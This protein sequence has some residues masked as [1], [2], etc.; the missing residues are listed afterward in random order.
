[1]KILEVEIF[2]PNEEEC[3]R[4]VEFNENDLSIIYGNI[5]MPT[6]KKA[7]SNSIGKTVL[8]KIVNVI[9]G[10]NNSGKDTIKGLNDYRIKAKVK[11]KDRIHNVKLIIGNS[12]G[13]YVDDVKMPISK[14]KEYFEIDRGKFSKQIMLEKRKGMI[15][16]MAA[17]ATKEDYSTILKLLY[18]GEID[19]KFKEIKQRQDQIA[20][21][22]KY[23]N[24]FKVS[25]ESLEQKKF[26]LEMENKK[27]SDEIKEL[28]TRINNLKIADDIT[29]VVEERTELDR[30]IKDLAEKSKLNKIKIK[31]YNEI[32]SEWSKNNISLDDVEKI[33]NRANI[34]V[35]TMV[36]RKLED[37]EAFYKN[38]IDDKSKIYTEQIE[39]LKEINEKINKEIEGKKVR[40]DSLSNIISENVSFKEA[41]K[42]YNLKTDE[43]M[44]IENQISEING[45]LEEISN[46]QEI[47]SEIEN[48]R[49]ELY[50]EFKKSEEKI[51][52][53]REFVYE[54]VNKVYG[55]NMEPYLS[56][57]MTESN[58]KYTAM[59]VKIELNL[60]GD[61]GEGIT[62]IKNLIFDC[63]IFKYNKEVEFLIEDSACFEGIDRRQVRKILDIME[64]ISTE[65]KKQLIVSLNK[66]ELED[67]DI[68]DFE[69]YIKVKLS[70]NV[71]L[72]HREF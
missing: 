24:E 5:E 29:D 51:N 12:K 28:N 18:L 17:K 9:L 44:K 3:I 50:T 65:E 47:K 15:S 19:K 14:Y 25:S 63:L 69:K 27:I 56:I 49:T 4:K 37:V 26:N 21:L 68:K 23:K 31:K 52:D 64:E 54:I 60:K 43:K 30:E 10:A 70:E 62:A 32:I 38:L 66:Y 34:E 48:L 33:Y 53:Y 58:N 22:K 39:N 59:P 46:T 16:S 11:Q 8:L 57:S 2:S 6:E 71:T 13:Y 55:E 20:L 1:M 35:P 7:T 41:M 61:T 36:T 72:L 42:I 45:K 40:L 67:E